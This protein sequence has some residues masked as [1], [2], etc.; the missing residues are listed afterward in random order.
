MLPLESSDK[1]LTA[2]I[3]EESSASGDRVISLAEVMELANMIAKFNGIANGAGSTTYG[4]QI[5]VRA[6][7]AEQAK[8]I[9]L[10]KFGQA[11][12]QAKLP[13]WPILSVEISGKESS[14]VEDG[15][16]LE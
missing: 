16:I 3:F 2:S 4:A 13:V 1:V 15:V 11:V 10:A 5:I 7:S 12:R 6:D 9:A 8:E 14:A